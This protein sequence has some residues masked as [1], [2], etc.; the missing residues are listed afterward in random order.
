MDGISLPKSTEYL[1][2]PPYLGPVNPYIAH[3]L[4]PVTKRFMNNNE[5]YFFARWV[6]YGSNDRAS[7]R[8]IGSVYFEGEEYTV[9]KGP[10]PSIKDPLW[11]H[12]DLPNFW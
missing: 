3:S 8:T 5:H 2:P 6:D 7:E 4:V 1:M 12:A 11:S 10:L 9:A